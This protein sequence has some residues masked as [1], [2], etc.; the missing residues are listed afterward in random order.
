[1]AVERNREGEKKEREVGRTKERKEE[2]REGKVY[3]RRRQRRKENM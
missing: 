1:M 3:S 2:K